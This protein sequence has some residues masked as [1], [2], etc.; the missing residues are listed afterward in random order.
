MTHVMDTTG[1]KNHMRR[2]KE[3]FNMA[4]LPALLAGPQ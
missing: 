4:G 2:L 3:K 1:K